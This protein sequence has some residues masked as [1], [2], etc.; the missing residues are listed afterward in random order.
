MVISSLLL[1]MLLLYKTYVGRA[2]NHNL[3]KNV[4]IAR[5]K[6]LTYYDNIFTLPLNNPSILISGII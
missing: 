5:L 1:L 4:I 3:L 6:L 2:K